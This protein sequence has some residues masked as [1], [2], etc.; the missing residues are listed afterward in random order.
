MERTPD[1]V[2]V[3]FE[4]QELTYRELN[5][6]AN[7]LAH[8]LR[9]SGSRAGNAGRPVSGALAR[10][11]GR[12]PRHPEGRRC[13]RAAGCGVSAA[14]AGS[15]CS[16]TRSVGFLVTQRR[17]LVSLPCCQLPDRVSGYRRRE[18]S[19]L[20]PVESA[21]QRRCGRPGLRDVHLRFHRAAKRRGD[22][23]YLHRAISCSETTT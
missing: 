15:S 19:G 4:D 10:A 3:V 16:P 6:R 22:S 1:A 9:S 14:A 20:R 18:P 13:L 5:E 23:T 8:Y 12:H 2:A 11:G 7:Q 21:G 17:L